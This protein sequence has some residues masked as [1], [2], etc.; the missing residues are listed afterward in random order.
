[1]TRARPAG[2]RRP[3]WLA[4]SAFPLVLVYLAG[5][6]IVDQATP[7][8]LRLDV[9]AAVAPVAAAALCTYRQTLVVSAI[10][11]TVMVITHGILPERLPA[12][13]RVAA[14][15]GNL[16]MVG[17][18][19]AVALLRRERER[20]LERVSATGEAAQRAL[21]R[22]L[23]LHTRQLVVDGFYISAQKDALVG[24]DIYEAVETPFGTRVTIGDVQGKGLGAIGTGAAVLTAFR[25][26][27][28]HRRS[29]ESA[30]KA[31]EEG[32]YRHYAE[33]ARDGDERFVTA[34]VFGT[35]AAGPSGD[36][37]PFSLSM[38]LV[39]CGHVAPYVIG[40]DG[41]VRELESGEPGLPLGLGELAAGQRRP[42]H[43]RLPAGSRVVACTDGVTE[44]RDASGAF[45]PLAKRLVQ[46]AAL[47]TVEL[48][49]RLEADLHAYTGGRM[50]DDVAVLVLNARPEP[51]GE[52]GGARV[53]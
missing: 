25:E 1:M 22:E 32:L 18:G 36:P 20:L 44:A 26:A 9:Y 6:V 52:A 38:T 43:V 8:Y 29:L 7:D 24:G 30:V 49:R 46:W 28:Y 34:L 19:I 16:L 35:E 3:T 21:I 51:Y 31:M 10:T 17:A 23:P 39:D 33:S 42:Q 47:P 13:N 2:R 11:L 40:A 5:I 4:T 41:T 14:I 15:F 12:M 50:N 48:L 53:G 27:A 37:D 45:Y